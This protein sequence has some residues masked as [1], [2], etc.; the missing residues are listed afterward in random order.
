[1]ARGAAVES[2]RTRRTLV[3]PTSGEA[4]LAALVECGLA[5][6]WKQREDIGDGSD[7]SRALR[8]R[9]QQRKRG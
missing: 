9:A 1:M 3:K 8:E 5:G 2:R 6:I 4:L 7:F